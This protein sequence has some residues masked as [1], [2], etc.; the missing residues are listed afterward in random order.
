MLPSPSQVEGVSGTQCCSMWK[1]CRERQSHWEN[2]HTFH[3]FSSAP[4]NTSS[5]FIRSDFFFFV[6]L[7]VLPLIVFPSKNKENP[8][9]LSSPTGEI[10][11]CHFAHNI[12]S[13]VKEPS[14]PLRS[15][16]LADRQ[17][18]KNWPKENRLI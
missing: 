9:C 13:P 4:C 8:G 6:Q 12:Y 15:L 3:S 2:K 17:T 18:G 14:L 11:P 10:T 16:H 1:S 7:L 5:S